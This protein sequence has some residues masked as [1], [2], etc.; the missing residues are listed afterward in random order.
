MAYLKIKPGDIF[1]IP[2]YQ[3]DETMGFVLARHISY[4]SGLNVAEIFSKFYTYLPLSI[5]QVDFSKRLFRP[6]F[7]SLEY[8]KTTTSKKW[9]ILFSDKNYEKS[10]SNYDSI[11]IVSPEGEYFIKSKSFIGGKDEL[12]TQEDT[13]IWMPLDLS[14]RASAHLNGF[15]GC[16][17]KF[18]WWKFSGIEKSSE[19]KNDLRKFVDRQFE[20]AKNVC[21]VIHDKIEKWMESA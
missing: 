7:C 19:N 15:F 1:Y 8:Y 9:R 18:D 6:V 14:I 11:T 17:E 4:H 16:N 5:D 12:T 3:S 21:D 2:V 20:I 10:Q 13:T